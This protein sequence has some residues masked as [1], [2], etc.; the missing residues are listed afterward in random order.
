MLFTDHSSNRYIL[1]TDV[2]DTLLAFIFSLSCREKFV[3][4]SPCGPL[5]DR[6]TIPS[7]RAWNSVIF[8]PPTHGS[9][10]QLFC[11]SK[12]SVKKA[13][14]PFIIPNSLAATRSLATSLLKARRKTT[15][16]NISKI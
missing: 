12:S 9:V 6:L 10:C 4:L 7:N 5:T 13:Y 2:R 1:T 16:T 8:L 3:N 15:E 14:S 11:I